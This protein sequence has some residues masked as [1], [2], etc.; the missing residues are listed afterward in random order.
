MRPFF[1]A[2][3]SL[4]AAVFV[5]ALRPAGM[6]RLVGPAQLQQVVAFPGEVGLAAASMIT[7][8]TLAACP[9]LRIAFSHGGGTL[10]AILPRLQHVWSITPAMRDKIALEPRQAV[11]TMFYDDLVYDAATV[12][13]LL[14]VFGETQ[15]MCGSD[16]P[17]TIR[18]QDP[19]GT[20][21]RLAVDD[22]IKE[23]MMVKNAERWLGE[24]P[25]GAL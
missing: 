1:E 6:D 25:A 7:G 23:L 11:R 10:Q 16:Y 20:I 13:R 15:L 18:D 4:G 24:A 2:A 3:E 17:F 9:N 19:A 8:G 22:R 5:H 21:D 12:D 14:S